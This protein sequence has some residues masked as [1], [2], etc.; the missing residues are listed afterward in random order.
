VTV[1]T[2]VFRNMC[3]ENIGRFP[4]FLPLPTDVENDDGFE[5]FFYPSIFQLRSDAVAT[6]SPTSS[7]RPSASGSPGVPS[8][9]KG[10]GAVALI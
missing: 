9:P 8:H 5:G 6:P 10:P 7:A 2:A 3:F 1:I 4:P